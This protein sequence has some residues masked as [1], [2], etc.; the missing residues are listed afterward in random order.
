MKKIFTLIIAV[1]SMLA[2]ANTAVAADV[3]FNVVVPT[4]TY[5]V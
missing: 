5:Q 2:F 1:F 4:P 3:T